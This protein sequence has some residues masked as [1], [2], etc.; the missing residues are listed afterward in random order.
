MTELGVQGFQ[1]IGGLKTDPQHGEYAQPMERQR[2]LESLV[3]AVGGRE[4]EEVQF[5]SEPPQLRACLRV[6]RSLIGLLGFREIADHVL[7]LVSR[8]AP[9]HCPAS[10]HGLDRLAQSLGSV[11][12]AQQTRLWAQPTIDQALQEGGTDPLVLGRRLHIAKDLLLPS[13]RDPQ[14][15]DDR[16]RRERLAV[17]HERDEL[18]QVQPPFTQGLQMP[19]A[20]SDKAAGDARHTQPKGGGHRLRTGFVLPTGQA[21]QDLPEQARICRPR[22]VELFV[23]GQGDLAVRRSVAYP[24]NGDGQFLIGQ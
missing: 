11:D 15:G 18:V 13:R 3:Q 7:P 6:R 16:V 8:A 9:H 20:R 4:V 24:R 2:L 5:L 1:A 23:R 12:H 22:A 19:G 17:E 21:H 14:R 10:E